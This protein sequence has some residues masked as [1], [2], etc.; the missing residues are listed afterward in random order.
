MRVFDWNRPAMLEGED[1]RQPLYKFQS[2]VVPA[3]V[4]RYWLH[5]KKKCQVLKSSV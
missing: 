5:G 4:G 1:W 2:V 3:V